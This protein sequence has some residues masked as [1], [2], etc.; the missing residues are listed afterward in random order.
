MLDL[1]LE[2]SGQLRE[3]SVVIGGGL[4]LEYLRGVVG[5]QDGH[6]GKGVKYRLL[7][8]RQ[9]FSSQEL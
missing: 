8:V 2:C 6:G 3:H 1:N 5:E 4:L 9:S 7:F